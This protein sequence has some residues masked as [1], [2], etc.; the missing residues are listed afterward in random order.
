MAKGTTATANGK[1]D[2]RGVQS[3]ELGAK[4]LT[5]LIEAA[6]P[7]MLKDV[8]R[9]A[10]FTPAQAHAYLVSY[11]KQGLVE[12]IDGLYR[13]GPFALELGMCRMTTSDPLRMASDAAMDLSLR[14]RLTVALTV[15]GSFGPTVIQ[16][17]ELGNHLNIKTRAGTV[18]SVTGTATGRSFAAFMPPRLIKE[19]IRL[20]K[21]DAEG[22]FRVG[23]PCLF[24][25]AE[26]RAVRSAGY[27]TIEE[28]PIPGI[29]AASAPVFD[30]VGQM[31]F[32]LTLIGPEAV[33]DTAPESEKVRM[34]LETTNRLSS[35]FGYEANALR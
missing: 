19:A 5:A 12:Q 17:Q 15:W 22:G 26:M 21:R 18:Y 20:E 27:A 2:G 13:L 34:L 24:S 31:Q 7:M 25:N 14:S 9:S 11:R 23:K 6:E 1:D 10:G 33:F 28:R 3:I 35:Y 32:A 29:A 16:I 30:H 8:A 4:L